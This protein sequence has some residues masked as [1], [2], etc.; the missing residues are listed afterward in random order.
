MYKRSLV[1]SIIIFCSMLSQAQEIQA[2]LTVLTSKVST[3][4][5]KKVFQTLQNALM[6]FLNNRRWTNDA[7][8]TSEKIQCN[9]LLN[10]DQDLGNNTFKGKLTVQ[11]ARP[12]YNTNYDSPIMNFLDDNI[13]FRYVEFQPVEFNENRIQGNDPMTANITAVLAYYVNLILGLDYDSFSLRGG[14]PYFQKAWNIVNNAPESRDITGWKSFES[15]R[16]RYWLAE[17]FNNSR[18]AL[19]HDALYSYYRTGMDIFFENEDAGRTGIQNCLNFLNTIN[20]ENPNSMFLQFFFQGKSTELVKVFSKANADQ[21]TRA[22][23]ILT[24]LDIT[25]GT[26]YKELK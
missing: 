6:N 16:N 5:D 13:V 25:N 18:F 14:D 11:A 23:D 4:V 2:R 24:K 17:N 9:F 22:R 10:I 26:A 3:Q 19:I 7:F 15:I 12:V 1:I 8:Q 20:N 21:K